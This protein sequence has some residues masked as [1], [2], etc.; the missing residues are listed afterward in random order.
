MFFFLNAI[1][2]N[3]P[4]PICHVNSKRIRTLWTLCAVVIYFQ[5]L[6]MTVS[7]IICRS[8]NL[9]NV[10]TENKK[11]P[12]SGKCLSYI[13]SICNTMVNC[14]YQRAPRHGEIRL[15]ALKNHRLN[16][17][18]AR[19]ANSVLESVCD[20]R[21][22]VWVSITRVRRILRDAHASTYRT[23]WM[24]FPMQL[25]PQQLSIKIRLRS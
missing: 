18:P 2:T 7:A 10:Q 24:T 16:F 4:S 17:R 5:A 11:K 19:K 13:L 14:K 9:L 23:L 6:W 25:Q 21:A 3:L 15:R 22:V 8:T 20:F 12:V 1:Y